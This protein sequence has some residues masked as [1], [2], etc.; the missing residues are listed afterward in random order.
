MLIFQTKRAQKTDP[1]QDPNDQAK[2][3]NVKNDLV[4]C[5]GIYFAE[6]FAIVPHMQ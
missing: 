1:Q 2:P 3:L 6:A 4:F 5:F